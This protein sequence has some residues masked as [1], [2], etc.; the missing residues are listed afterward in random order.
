MLPSESSRRRIAWPRVDLPD[1]IRDAQGLARCTFRLMPSTAQ[2]VR[3]ETGATDGKLHPQI[4]HLQDVLA[5]VP[6]QGF[7]FRF[8]IEQDGCKG[9]SVR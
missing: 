4:L 6:G 9:A 1:R 7:A 3:A 8:G 2:E 5:F